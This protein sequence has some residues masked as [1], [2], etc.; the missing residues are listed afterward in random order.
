[1]LESN[2]AYRAVRFTEVVRISEG[3]EV[4]LYSMDHVY[5]TDGALGPYNT[6]DPIPFFLQSRTIQSKR[7]ENDTRR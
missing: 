4:P 2:V 5:C 7:E 3:P 1:M 6:H